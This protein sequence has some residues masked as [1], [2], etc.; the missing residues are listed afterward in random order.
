MTPAALRAAAALT[1]GDHLTLSSLPDGFA[2]LVLADL[3]RELAKESEAAA[4][5]IYV[6]R[7]GQRLALVEA[8]LAFVAPDV[9]VLSLPAWDCQP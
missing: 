1:R 4:A 5:L 3:T 9:E 2:P 8:G 7:D 6:A